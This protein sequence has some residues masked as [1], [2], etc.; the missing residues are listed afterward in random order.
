MNRTN[1]IL[2]ALLA[3]QLVVAAVI[4]WPRPAASGESV[5]LVPDIEADKIVE[6]TITDASGRTITLGRKDGSWVLPQ[7]G[8]YPAEPEPVNTLVTK[9][10]GL[11]A[12]RVVTQTSASHKR[13]KVAEDDFERRIDLQMADGSRVRLYVGNSPSWGAAHVRADGQDEVYLTRELTAQD[14]GAE[15]ASW[16]DTIY[17][18]VPMEEIVRITVENAQGTLDLK[19]E[20]DAW[21]LEGLPADETLD[22]AKVNGLL[23]RVTS[24][25]LLEPVG[26]GDPA[27]YGLDKPQA[28]VTVYTGEGGTHVLRVGTQDPE[29]KSYV[30]DSSDSEYYVRVREFVVKNLVEYGRQDLLVPPPTQGPEEGPEATPEG[31]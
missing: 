21:A 10:A 31:P 22:E 23:S 24:V 18:S 1:R 7:A 17:M 6:L 20:G 25:S 12:D 4:L 2:A 5:S 19:K 11:K 28:V 27:D 26:K 30:V 29:D 8:D 14:A 9:I 3:L 13:L 16:V 15:A